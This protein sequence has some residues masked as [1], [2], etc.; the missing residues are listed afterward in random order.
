MANT[1]KVGDKFKP[2]DKVQRSGIYKVLHDET[3]TENHEVTCVFGK[4]F[5]PC[6]DCGSGVQFEL[7]RVAQHIESNEYFSGK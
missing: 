3:H 7:V 5:P 4:T 2:G 6:R 1:T